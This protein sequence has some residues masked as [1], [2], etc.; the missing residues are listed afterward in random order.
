MAKK[1]AAQSILWPNGGFD[2]T[3]KNIQRLPTVRHIRTRALRTYCKTP[4]TF[5]DDKYGFIAKELAQI[6]AE[7]GTN[8]QLWDSTTPKSLTSNAALSSSNEAQWTELFAKVI[9]HRINLGDEEIAYSNA[10]WA[11]QA[12]ISTKGLVFAI[13]P[14]IDLYAAGYAKID[15][16]DYAYQFPRATQYTVWLREAIACCD[17]VVH[18][19]IMNVLELHS[20]SSIPLRRFRALIAP[21]RSDWVAQSYEE[22]KSYQVIADFLAASSQSTQCLPLPSA[23]PE[24]KKALFGTRHCCCK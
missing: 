2:W 22:K 9:L 15:P 13:K 7:L 1:N 20:G 3:P 18:E 4:I 21:H 5:N 24:K 19:Q 11:V 16:K 17:D 6:N 23:L 12:C 10:E 14:I 8:W